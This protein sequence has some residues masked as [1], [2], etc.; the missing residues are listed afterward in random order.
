[1]ELTIFNLITIAHHLPYTIY[2]YDYKNYFEI[3]II[4]IKRNLS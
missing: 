2:P 4:E 1:M 3:M